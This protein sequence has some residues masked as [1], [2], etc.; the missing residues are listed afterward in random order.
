MA[1]RALRPRDRNYRVSD[2]GWLYI[3]VAPTGQKRWRWKYRFAG[4]ES[5]LGFGSYPAVSLA[6]ARR[7]RDAGRLLLNSGKN[8]SAHARMAR[9]ETIERAANSFSAIAAEWFDQNAHRLT[10]GL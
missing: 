3:E 1:L 10:L 5:M 8:P 2:G 6:E 9:L 7:K 4:K